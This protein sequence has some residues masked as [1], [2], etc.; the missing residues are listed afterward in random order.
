[1]S[2]LILRIDRTVHYLLDKYETPELVFEPD[3]DV[4]LVP[5]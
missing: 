5:F 4:L 2:F 1:M 3:D